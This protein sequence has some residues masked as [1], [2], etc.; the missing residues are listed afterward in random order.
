MS[1]RSDP[2]SDPDIPRDDCN[3]TIKTNFPTPVL[4]VSQS[5][6]SSGEDV[7]QNTLD[8]LSRVDIQGGDQA[9]RSAG[10]TFSREVPASGS[11]APPCES[12]SQVS[13][14]N[15]RSS[16]S[17]KLATTGTVKQPSARTS[18]F[19]PIMRRDFF[20]CDSD[21]LSLGELSRYLRQPG[22]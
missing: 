16:T 20:D 17:T 9:S 12:P 19:F 2:Q 15:L 4:A 10:A 14:E 5:S 13:H 6:G 21:V 18:A 7:N 1:V 8:Y 3:Q 22:I 11:S